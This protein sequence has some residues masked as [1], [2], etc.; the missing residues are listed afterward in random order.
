[1]IA[2]GRNKKHIAVGVFLAANVFGPLPIV[3]RL[4][5]VHFGF[6]LFPENGTLLLWWILLL[7]AGFTA[8]ISALGFIFITSMSY[9]IVEDVQRATKRREEGLLGTV[10]SFVHKIVGAG[11]VLVS[12]IIIGAVGFDAP[13]VTLA[14]L[15]GPVVNKFALIH[16][17]LGCTMPFIS[18]L[19]VLLYNIDR[20]GHQ[21]NIKDLGYV[22][23]I[24]TQA[25]AVDTES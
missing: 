6:S 16:V 13:G 9:E 19:L 20:K 17:V 3:L 18:T 12:G 5:D 23:E 10:N 11:G 8:S 4:L 2:K 21:E 1:M 24:G 7:H 22:E 25:K 14:Q 15:Q